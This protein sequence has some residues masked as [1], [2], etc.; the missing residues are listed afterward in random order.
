MAAPSDETLMAYADDALPPDEARAVE[1][2]LTGDAALA[3]K[4]AMFR[5][6]RMRSC[7]ALLPLAAEPVP[8]ALLA[9][10]R[11][12]AAAPATA[13]AD[14]VPFRPRAKRPVAA[15]VMSLAAVRA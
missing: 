6:T 7:E 11:A 1:A 8:D 15:W 5:R 13:P 10:I 3:A 12:A 14:V 9:R 2:A 4:V